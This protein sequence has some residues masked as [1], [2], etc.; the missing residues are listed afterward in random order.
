MPTDTEARARRVVA[1]EVT[2]RRGWL[3]SVWTTRTR[4]VIKE[5]VAHLF[6]I[7]ISI[8]MVIPLYWLFTTSLKPK[9]MV[10]TY[11][12]QWIPNPIRWENYPEALT[13]LP[14]HLFFKNSMVYCVTILIGQVLVS[15]LV[16]YG[17]ARLRFPG[18]DLIFWLVLIRMMLPGAVTM[19]PSYVMFSKMGW[20]NT[21]LPLVVPGW[22]PGLYSGSFYIF[23]CRQFF[24]G[25]PLEL[26][27]AAK[28][29]GAGHIRI[30]WQIILP[31]SKPVIATVAIFSFI[32]HWNDFMGPLIYLHDVER[33][34]LALS[35]LTFQGAHDTEWHWLMAVSS[36]MVVPVIILF[37]SAQ[38]YF[39]Q[40]ISMTGI[41]GR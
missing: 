18:R 12:P 14:F 38:R 21:L 37:F 32:T 36:L 28:I 17:F 9:G 33:Q 2:E 13:I 3:S 15:T 24:M 8:T 11:P 20:V 7:P 22:L 40:G 29:D 27:D 10:F 34:T 35:I 39:L 26:D 1:R 23:L 5:L 19:V 4:S 41:T 16:G 31:L 25:I 6:L 30:W